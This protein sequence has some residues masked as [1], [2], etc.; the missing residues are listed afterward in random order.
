MNRHPQHFC[1]T[2]SLAEHDAPAPSHHLIDL[3]SDEL[4]M[5][6]SLTNGKGCSSSSRTSPSAGIKALVFALFRHIAAPL[7]QR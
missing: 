2:S 5:L 1:V 6:A 3:T 7:A 4:A